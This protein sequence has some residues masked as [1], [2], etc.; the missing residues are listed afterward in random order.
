MWRVVALDWR[1][2]L[3]PLLA[4]LPLTE[5]RWLEPD[6]S[7]SV[8]VMTLTKLAKRFLIHFFS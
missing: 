7:F 5:R 2:P 4:V 6:G 1:V 8:A 3:R